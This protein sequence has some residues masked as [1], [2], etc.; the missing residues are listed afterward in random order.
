MDIEIIRKL[1]TA[2][3]DA[4]EGCDRGA[5]GIS[6]QHFPAGSCGD[7]VPLLGT[8]LQDQGTGIFSY[9]L[10]MRGEAPNQQ[11]HAW[12]ERDGVIVDITADQFEEM[13]E[14]VIVTKQSAWHQSFEQKVPHIADYRVFDRLAA[15]EL[16]AKYHAILEKMG[17]K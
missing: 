4:I 13:T 15:A 12:L 16:A 17:G 10:G 8:F 6:F 7:V 9:V 3:R 2:F 14:R 1:A 11:S 5:L